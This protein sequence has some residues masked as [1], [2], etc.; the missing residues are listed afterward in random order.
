MTFRS[1]PELERYLR[2]LI[3]AKITAE[4]P[5]IYA[6]KSKKAVDIVICRNGVH[7][8]VFFLEVKLFQQKH[9]RLGIGTGGG[10]G[11]QPEIV[12]C[13]P[14]YF[15]SHLRWVIVDGREPSASFLFVP[16][17]KITQFLAG[18]KIG[19]KFNNIQ[20][21]IFEEVTPLAEDTLV[22][23]LCKWLLSV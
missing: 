3:A 17:S 1:E 2:D 8:A 6:L 23:E 13:N 20:L 21:R 18:S 11:Y 16:T 5:H 9:G 19:E 12:S 14:D 7:P 22:H 15:E 4:Y 10:G